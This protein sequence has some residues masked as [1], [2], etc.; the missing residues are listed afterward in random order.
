[1]KKMSMGIVLI[2]F[3]VFLSSC[4]SE[5][6]LEEKMKDDIFV[7]TQTSNEID[8]EHIFSVT[9]DKN[10]NISINTIETT[11]WYQTMHDSKPVLDENT[12]YNIAEQN[13]CGFI[14]NIIDEGICIYGYN[15][16]DN[17]VVIPEYIEGFQTIAVNIPLISE[18]QID[19]LT[20]P[21]T[22]TN[23]TVNDSREND[24][25]LYYIDNENRQYISVNGVIY[26]NDGSKLVKFPCAN[27]ALDFIVPDSV[28]EIGACSFKY[29]ENLKSVT[30][31][32]NVKK[33]CEGAFSQANALENIIMKNGVEEI[34]WYAFMGCNSLHSIEL[35]ASVKTIGNC[36]FNYCYN[37]SSITLHTGITKI[38]LGIFYENAITDIK[39]IEDGDGI[40]LENDI[41]C[42]GNAMVKMLPQ[43]DVET[44][45]IDKNVNLLGF[46]FENRTNLKEIII[47]DGCNVEGI[48]GG[49]FSGCSSVERIYIPNSVKYAFNFNE[50]SAD[51]LVIYT[52]K[53]SIADEIAIRQG[54]PVVHVNSYADYLNIIKIC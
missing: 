34:G 21:K 24:V 32:E 54:F 41:I 1:M 33:I 44:L 10:I 29:C 12:D 39:I 27:D 30:I 31:G 47:E 4:Q 53:D 15:G 49:D 8:S 48:V 46:V 38:G 52:Q 14:Y 35:P 9:S 28:A 11:S 22:V 42:C 26:T 40:I 5:E 51:S 25:K 20:I 6:I 16:M 43:S 18:K 45:V 37:L 19:S 17:D 7:Y 50:F 2:F 13:A 36:A 3:V 23:I